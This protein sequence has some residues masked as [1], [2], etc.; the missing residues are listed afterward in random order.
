MRDSL[1]AV[2]S[3]KVLLE[4]VTYETQSSSPLSFEFRLRRLTL[5]A[6]KDPGKL[7]QALGP[8]PPDHRFS[9]LNMV[10]LRSF[11]R[12]QLR[13]GRIPRSRYSSEGLGRVKRGELVRICVAFGAVPG[14]S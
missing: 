11:A 6:F 4:R 8:L 2:E 12:A 10:K 13:A 5:L 14:V 3:L 9:H 1:V 7:E